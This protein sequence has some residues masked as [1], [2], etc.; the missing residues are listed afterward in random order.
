MRRSLALVALGALV[1][2][3]LAQSSE[4]YISDGNSLRI[5]VV[6]GGSV[7]RSWVGRDDAMPIAV[8]NTVRTYGEYAQDFGSEYSLGGT[9]SG[10]DY[11]HQGESN[12]GQN[13]DGGTDGV[14]RN[15]LSAWN[16]NA[17]WQSDLNWQNWTMLFAVSGPTGVT[18][19]QRTGNLWVATF[20][21]RA[22]TQYTTSGT[23][24][25]Q[26]NYTTQ[27]QWIG[28]LA[29]EP[30]TDTL[31]A[32][33]FANGRL[34]NYRKDGTL[35]GTVDVPALAGYAWGGEFAIPEPASLT[36]IASGLA[37]MLRRRR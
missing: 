2:P 21:N 31:W 12:R 11:P 15:F 18:Y 22:I 14:R 13:T 30:A 33:D 3:S 28:C 27:S 34:Y 9:W 6:Q 4:Y 19:D 26:F 32:E 7:V 24:V 35:L 5:S 25:S 1:A 17:I 20:P 16:G 8:I 10:T 37:L 23:V 29:Y 36:L